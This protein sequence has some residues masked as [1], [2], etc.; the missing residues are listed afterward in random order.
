MTIKLNTSIKLYFLPAIMS[1]VILITGIYGINKLNTLNQITETIYTD[2]LVPIQQL[3]SVH[4]FYESN[5]LSIASKARNHQLTYQQAEKQLTQSEQKSTLIWQAYQNTSFTPAETLLIQ[6][7]NVLIQKAK[8]TLEK[9]KTILKTNDSKALDNFIGTDFYQTVEPVA[10]KINQLIELQVKISDEQIRMS[11]ETYQKTQRNAYLFLFISLSFFVLLGFYI[12]KNIRFLIKNL[13]SGSKAILGTFQDITE[14][15]NAELK[16]EQSEQKNRALIENITDAIVLLD[17]N[18]QVTYQSPSVERITGY[19]F[20]DRNKGQTYEFVYKEDQ[21]KAIE[22]V[23]KSMREPNVATSYQLRLN[24]KE[25]RIIWIEATIL[26]LLHNENVKA[27]VVTYRDIT[28]K[29]KA[30]ELFK[31]QFENSPDII[32]IVNRNL[33]IESIN[34]GRPGGP[35]IEELIG[36]CSIE[37]LPEET[38][39]IAKETLLECFE[40]GKNQEIENPLRNNRWVRSRFVPIVIEGMINQIMVIS[41]DITEQKFAQE[42][43]KRS[44]ERHKSLIENISD[45]I[46]LVNKELEV[47]YQSPSFVRTAG[48]TLKDQKG[49]T[50]LDMIHPDDLK[51]GLKFF[52]KTKT[53]PGAIIPFQLRLFHKRG[54]FIWVE[55]T[56]TNLLHNNSV[57]AYVLNYRDITFRKLMESERLKIIDELIQRNRD[58]EQFAYIISHNLRA[59]VANIIGITDYLKEEDIEPEEKHQ[60]TEGLRISVRA[61]DTVIN[62]L[63]TILQTKREII[64]KK[65]K[66]NFSKILTDVQLSIETLINNEQVVFITDFSAIDEMI[67]IKS[68]LHSIF[69][70]LISNSIKYK[71]PHIAPVIEIRSKLSENKIILFFKDNGL[72]IDL[73]KRGE[74]VFGLYKRFHTQIEGKGMGLYMVK[75][76]VETLGGKIS[77]KSK[78]NEGTEFK[79]I[80]EIEKRQ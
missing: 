26:N 48:F 16:L 80:F 47:I 43:L 35:S 52:E 72:G 78:I 66:I 71:Q 54:D 41:T 34:R 15:K 6:E 38:Q 63:N 2:R 39:A 70:N 9:L 68:Y 5:L 42:N 73:E 79:I 55:G 30:T 64:E 75:T 76:Q 40:T 69:Y 44:E 19:S 17:A 13:Q 53:S 67:T 36:Q 60:M 10:S 74:Q 14:R 21:A 56:V 51:D 24:H 12:I 31:T 8:P 23:Q 58:L 46:I 11:G 32:L 77:I 25:G 1:V 62:D 22:M 3:S 59:P 49:K 45:T 37:V 65:E 50:V 20:E 27:L 29:K 33:T 61:L 57:K 18:G 7:S 28:A 4:L